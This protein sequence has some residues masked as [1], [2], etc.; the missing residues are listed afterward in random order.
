M[1][2]AVDPGDTVE[3]VTL[4][5]A[6][7]L[8]QRPK[9]LRIIEEGGAYKVK[10]TA[11]LPS[12]HRMAKWCAN[13]ATTVT[14][15][16]V[17][18]QSLGTTEAPWRAVIWAGN[19]SHISADGMTGFP[20]IGTPTVRLQENAPAKAVVRIA[21][22]K[23]SANV[24]A[25][26]FAGWS[27]GHQEAVAKGME[28]TVEYRRPDGVMAMVFRGMVYQVTD[29]DGVELTAYDRLMDLYQ[30][31]GQYQNHY[32]M[33]DGWYTRQRI[34]A[35]RF[36]F[37]AG[38]AV[39]QV[40]QATTESIY[41]ISNLDGLSPDGEATGYVIHTLPSV[42]VDGVTYG[43]ATGG[44]IKRVEVEGVYTKGSHQTGYLS[45]RPL[46]YWRD[47]AN[48]TYTLEQYGI[49]HIWL[50]SNSGRHIVRWS[51]DVDWPLTRSG[52]G[53]Y[54]IGA[55]F[56]ALSDNDNGWTGTTDPKTRSAGVY[57][58]EDGTTW[59]YRT[60]MKAP[61]ISVDFTQQTA[62]NDP[63][64]AVAVSGTS[65]GILDGSV[66]N[67]A[68]TYVN[69]IDR[70]T[71]AYLKYFVQSATPL[72]TIAKDLME[73]AGLVP[74]AAAEVDLGATT[75][76][77]SSTFNYL[78]LLRELLDGSGYG[79]AAEIQEPGA[80]RIAP[81][82]SRTETPVLA[83]STEAGTAAGE[84]I[85]LKHDIT[86]NWAAEKATV[87]Y[88]A[89]DATSSGLPLALETD[90]GIHGEGG[91]P[92]SLSTDLQSP[93]RG[94]TADNTLGTH[95]LMAMAAGHKVAK[96]HT[97]TVDGTITLA[98]YRTDLW[99]TG[100]GTGGLPLG[101][102][103]PQYGLDGVTV[104]PKELEIGNGSTRVVLDNVSA[105]ER[106]ELAR[107]MGRTDDAISNAV[108]AFPATVYVFARYYGPHSFEDLPM[109]GQITVRLLKDDGTALVA[110]TDQARIKTV[111]DA[112]GYIHICAV[113]E[114]SQAG[115]A[116]DHPVTAV[117][118]GFTGGQSYTVPLNTPAYI[119]GGQMV[120]IDVRLQGYLI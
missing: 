83:V 7:G 10:G 86:V 51:W 68:S 37:D 99:D 21:E 111:D 115:Y 56:R 106:S 95:A 87:A 19:G 119:L 72:L 8:G 1:A 101:L 71:Q 26:T 108:R 54:L 36:W 81:A 25:P 4:P 29:G 2:T 13:D 96:L 88:I 73:Q 18:P 97:N 63:A 89:E 12:G 6:G 103:I 67:V 104:I 113:K 32:G 15:Y 5:A 27:D 66:P 57:Y 85:V 59:E 65:F 17:N 90:D 117:A 107:S 62:V 94:I 120:H 102:Y 39:G 77:Q 55:E 70:A 105:N 112:Q 3:A 43:P 82:H 61:E 28:L 98:G 78:D 49:A 11:Q 79:M 42:T 35:G 31:S 118:V 23:G 92:G 69:S 24:L 20:T 44:R 74:Q 64:T 41:R 53:I 116:T 76:Y 14:D 45:I 80:V 114:A 93:L 50:D 38:V 9:W 100:T 22:M 60:N 58:S 109:S 75:F 91:V 48:R 52:G 46:L 30:F 47:S 16:F 40:V 110:V 84:Y 33:N 34:D